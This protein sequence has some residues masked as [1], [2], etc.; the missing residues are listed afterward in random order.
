MLFTRQFPSIMLCEECEKD[1]QSQ[2]VHKAQ[3]S[4]S[5]CCNTCFWTCGVQNKRTSSTHI[6]YKPIIMQTNVRAASGLTH[7]EERVCEEKAHLRI[8][9]KE[10]DHRTFDPPTTV[11][12][13]KLISNGKSTAKTQRILGREGGGQRNC[14]RK[15]F[16]AGREGVS[17]KLFTTCLAQ[18]SASKS[19]CTFGK[20]LLEMPNDRT[21]LAQNDPTICH[22]YDGAFGRA[23]M[24][25]FMVQSGGST[26]SKNCH[27]EREHHSNTT[28]RNS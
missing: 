4:C 6:V 13:N 12:R 9:P 15:E 16:W 22:G 20:M 2:I 14:S 25:E 27:L 21:H 3:K 5:T 18:T 11:W 1:F 24:E 26:D 10:R 23:Q 19:F 8:T 17:K 28:R 7:E